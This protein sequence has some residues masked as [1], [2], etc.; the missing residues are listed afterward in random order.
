MFTYGKLARLLDLTIPL[1]LNDFSMLDTKN[2]VLPIPPN[3]RIKKLGYVLWQ[4]I[5]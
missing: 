1:K 5:W 4:K 3:A 2:S